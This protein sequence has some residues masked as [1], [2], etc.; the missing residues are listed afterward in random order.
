MQF[1]AVQKYTRTSP[2]KLRLVANQVKDLS[3]ADAIKQLAVMERRATLPLL[4][5]L[6]QAIANANHN[7]GVGVD[8]LSVQEMVI[9]TG[10][11]YKRFRAVSRGRAHT[12]LKRT[13][14]I[15]VV[16]TDQATQQADKKIDTTEKVE[17]V[18]PTETEPKQKKVVTKKATTKKTTKTT[19]ESKTTK[20]SASKKASKTK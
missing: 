1:I 2:R 18:K 19:K 8:Q 15:R 9:N 4:K 10:P 5:T 16:L 7:H 11:T 17:A 3:L 13:S 12:I 20:K 6:R 14:H